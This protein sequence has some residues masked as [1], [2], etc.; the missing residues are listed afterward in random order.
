VY[1]SGTGRVCAGCGWPAAAC[2]C[3]ARDTRDAP[4]P[5]APTVVVRLERKG[6]GGKTVTV[7]EGLP[8]NAAFVEQLAR[9]LKKAC[10]TG[11]A[12]R[13]TAIELQGDRRD[14]VRRILEARGI[15]AR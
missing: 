5:A 8:R 14:A 1:S 15:R 4:V 9:D 13:E 3:A 10:A 2:R 7:I 6:R 12:A 11:G